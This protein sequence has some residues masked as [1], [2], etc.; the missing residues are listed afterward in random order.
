MLNRPI[1]A[2]LRL[3]RIGRTLIH[4]QA[5]RLRD[6][7]PVGWRARRSP[8]TGTP[9]ERLPDHL[10]PLAPCNI[11][12]GTRFSA[13]HVA[14]PL[15]HSGRLRKCLRCRS[16]ERHRAFRKITV[17]M[18]KADFKQARCLHLSRDPTVKPRWFASYE[19]SLYGKHNSID[20]QR[21]PRGDASYDVI[22]CTHVLEHVPDHR[23]ALRELGR[24]LSDHGFLFLSVPDPLRRGR[25]EDWGHP[26]PHRFGHYREFGPDF[27]DLLKQELP[28][29]SIVAVHSID[30]V[31]GD[32][33]AAY[34][35]T[36]NR[37][38]FRS[39]RQLPFRRRIHA[40]RPFAA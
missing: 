17:W 8:C 14:N 28:D 10:R 24:V 1:G 2:P 37:R 29:L 25:T 32:A 6:L 9:G 38:R 18:G 40:E 15:S 13:G 23:R 7:A 30:H 19:L 26:D 27:A 21:I 20:V 34:I 11:C 36:C 4:R 3:P 5:E 22:V 16:P 33:D 35:L 39:A 12:G 31:T